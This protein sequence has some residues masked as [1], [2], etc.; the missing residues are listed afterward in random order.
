M[1]IIFLII[2]FSASV[3]G[4]IC[5]IG[6]GI[7]IKPILDATNT[8]GVSEISF[9]SGCVVLSMAII[10]VFKSMKRGD[11]LVEFK[12]GTP[13]AIGAAIGGIFGKEIF[14]F[15]YILYPSENMVGAMQAIV[16][17][18]LT[19]GTLIYTL[20]KAR[21][22]THDISNIMVCVAIG[23]L[24][25]CLSA[26][27]GIGGGPINLIVLAFFF[28]MEEKQAAVNSLY[29]ILF[30]QATSLLSTV[31]GG[32]VPEVDLLLV[33]LMIAGGAGGGMVGSK[34]SQKISGSLVNRLFIGM[35]IVIIG[36][37]LYNTISFL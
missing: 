31:V 27:L 12:T 11:K 8:L 26:F 37:S 7:I 17:T 2:S 22:K 20:K 19:I 30:S 4:A 10:S 5:G 29:I 15:A 25:G 21:I 35:M 6:G 18:I 14:Q 3:I 13:I 23:L 36:I 9:L 1:N 28:S 34:V 24:L 16:L 33:L 32:S